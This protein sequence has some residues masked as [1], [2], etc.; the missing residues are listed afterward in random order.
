MKK[1]LFLSSLAMLMTASMV[2]GG[3]GDSKKESKSEKEDN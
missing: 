2:L 1:R 3:C